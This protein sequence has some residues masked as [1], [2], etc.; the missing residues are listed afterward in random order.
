[1]RLLP[2]HLEENDTRDLLNA[3]SIERVLFYEKPSGEWIIE[4]LLKTDKEK[5]TFYIGY[6]KELVSREHDILIEWLTMPT[7]DIDYENYDSQ[8]NDFR[9]YRED[10]LN[11]R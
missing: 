7:R 3:D 6:D 5:L 4:I 9:A 8:C 2:I 1:M 11:Y 10:R